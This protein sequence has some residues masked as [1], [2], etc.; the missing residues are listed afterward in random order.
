MADIVERLRNSGSR[1]EIELHE[2]REEAADRIAEL[3]AALRNCVEMLDQLVDESGRSIEW[4]EEDP[5]R[6]GEW[7][8]PE[9]LAKIEIARAALKGDCDGGT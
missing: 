1:T 4:D 6:R 5:F 7:F 3:E 8:W 9:D 2:D